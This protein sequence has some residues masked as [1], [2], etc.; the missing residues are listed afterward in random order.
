MQF[1]NLFSTIDIGPV[2]VPNRIVSTGHH[3]YLAHEH[4]SEELIAYHEARAQ[5]GVGLIISEITAIHDTAMFSGQLLMAL[6]EDCIPHYKRLADRVH[7]HGTKLFGQLFHQ[8][9]ELLS[10]T[11]GLI[12]PAY[13]PSAVPNERFHI[14]PQPMPLDLIGEVIDGYARAAGLLAAAGYDGVEIVANQGYLPSQFFNPRVNLRDDAY[15]GDYE[16]R[17]TFIRKII[18]EI[19]Q[20]APNLALGIRISGDEMDEQGLGSELVS[21]VCISLANDLDYLSVVAGT[22][23]SLGGSV[24]VVPPMGLESGYTAPYAKNIRMATGKPVIVTGRINQPQIA[25]GIL[26]NDHADLC[27]MTR[28]LIADPEMPNKALAGQWDDI[29]ACI[30]CNQ[31]CIGRAHKGLGISCIQNPVSGRE[32]LFTAMPPVEHPK[33][34]AVIG[35]GPAGMQAAVLAAERGHQVSLHESATHLGGQALLAQKLPGREEFGGLVTNLERELSRAE[36][37]VITGTL[38]T[39]DS[40]RAL[41]P[42]VVVLATGATPYMPQFDG[43]DEGHVVTA[44]QVLDDEVKVGASVV[45]ADWRADWIGVGL[46]E[47]LALSGSAVTL[48]TNAAMAG[49]TLQIYT[50][51]HYVGRLHKL[52]V[53]IRTHARLYG[54]DGDTAYFQDTLTEDPIVIDGIDS[55]VLSLGHSAV[56]DLRRELNDA[57]FSVMAA[58]DCITPRTA[59]EAVYEGFIVGT[60][61]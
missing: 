39:E 57:P 58:G 33:T 8:G 5:G 4:P 50:R 1:T 51:N 17:L 45:I 9:R 22:S 30:A 15:G 6:N 3:T 12:P 35:G 26:R 28:A 38:M 21:Q 41:D 19:R 11:S 56:S 53:T 16:R 47:R 20:T 32:T 23:A 10:S 54:V 29:R 52:G 2:T 31:S 34:V 18:Q 36:V 25:E 13:A 60:T 7:V 40:I 44:W 49:E 59:E 24:H 48:C 42:D 55:V 27:G 43:C 46:A 14:M 37:R 61:I